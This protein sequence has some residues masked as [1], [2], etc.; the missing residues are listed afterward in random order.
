MSQ[1]LHLVGNGMK[2][3]VVCVDVTKAWSDI[4]TT[5]SAFSLWKKELINF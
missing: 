1:L 5:R 3:K 2:R 4:K